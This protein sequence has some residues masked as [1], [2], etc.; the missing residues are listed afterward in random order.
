MSLFLSF[1]FLS[2][3]CCSFVTV[4]VYT[5]KCVYLCRMLLIHSV[6]CSVTIVLLCYMCVGGLG[7]CVVF[8]GGSA[9]IAYYNSFHN[10][11]RLLFWFILNFSIYLLISRICICFIFQIIC[12]FFWCCESLFVID[13]SNSIKKN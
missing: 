7:G 1:F 12:H 11:K 5:H 9:S 10:F 13:D 3:L 8:L 4:V 2:L 6:E